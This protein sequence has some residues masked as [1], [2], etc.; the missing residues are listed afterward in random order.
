MSSRGLKCS[1][2]SYEKSSLVFN[3]MAYGDRG[4]GRETSRDYHTRAVRRMG[5]GQGGGWEKGLWVGDM[6]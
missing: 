1:D 6:H 5:L 3:K 4:G 2:L